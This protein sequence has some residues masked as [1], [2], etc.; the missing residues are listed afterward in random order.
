[1]YRAQDGYATERLK[2]RNIEQESQIDTTEAAKECT[3]APSLTNRS[4]AIC[5][6]S[7]HKP[8][9]ERY[10]QEIR[11]KKETIQKLKIALE[12]EKLEK[13]AKIESEIAKL[14]ASRTLSKTKKVKPA[15][16]LSQDKDLQAGIPVTKLD[17]YTRNLMWHEKKKQKLLEI[18]NERRVL[19]SKESETIQ[20]VG[21]KIK[22]SVNQD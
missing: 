3:F 10:K 17:T 2:K 13:E 12:E 20:K 19:E 4:R 14:R 7:G 22:P 9:Y 18:Q 11:S 6:R 1:M 5:E 21:S 16:S 8:I 15:T